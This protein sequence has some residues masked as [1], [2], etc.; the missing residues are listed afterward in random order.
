V[1][2]RLTDLRRRCKS[3]REHPVGQSSFRTLVTN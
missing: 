1:D 2:A 3:A